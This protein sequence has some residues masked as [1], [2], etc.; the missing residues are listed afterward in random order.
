MMCSRGLSGSVFGKVHM[1]CFGTLQNH[2]GIVAPAVQGNKLDSKKSLL[3]SKLSL[4]VQPSRLSSSGDHVALWTAEK[5]VS[6]VLL[7]VIPLALMFPTPALDYLMAFAITIHSHWG[8]EAIVV[9]YIRESV[10][11]PVI[12]K[13]GVAL[14]YA[15][16]AATL[17]GL[18]YFTYSDV[19][20]S[21][22][23]RMLW[24]L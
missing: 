16:S 24:K 19:G 18:F 13:L 10:F 21:N 5:V 23:I 17:G 12:P 6:G 22:A 8:I 9:D 14:V 3:P 20:L 4:Q 7:P 2:K 1:G 15:L 11:G